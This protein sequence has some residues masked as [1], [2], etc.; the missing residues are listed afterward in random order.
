MWD[1]LSERLFGP[2]PIV[3]LALVRLL[4]P[5]ALVGFLFRRA[6]HATD[7]LSTSGFRVPSEL[8]DWRQP[9]PLPALPEWAAW[10]VAMA[11]VIS[12]LMLA[13][14]AFTR[15]SGLAFAA[16]AAYVG[17]ADRL[18]AFTLTKVAPMIGLAL[19]LTPSGARL[20]VDEWRARRRGQKKLP[21][22]VSGGCVS[23]F[24][25][26]LGVFYFTSALEKMHGSWLG[27]WYVLWT[28]LH[29]SYQTHISYWIAEL[30]PSWVWPPLQLTVLIYEAGAALLYSIKWTRTPML[31][32][33]L[34]MHLMIGL[35]FGPVIFF[36]WF[37]MSLL[38]GVFAPMTWLERVPALRRANQP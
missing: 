27:N 31:I 38:V 16:L 26:F 37:M 29:D 11:L 20:S 13:A 28:H 18:S 17:L 3:R 25:V 5:L 35:L 21:T 32:Y 34:A 30:T 23:F 1:A 8:V 36:S 10:L 7:W 22:K 12:G 9:L 4:A 6:I 2:K 14:G 19:A 15:W 24:Q 33:G